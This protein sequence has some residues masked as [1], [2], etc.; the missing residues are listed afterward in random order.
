MSPMPPTALTTLS[1][2]SEPSNPLVQA[3]RALSGCPPDS[4]PRL[5]GSQPLPGLPPSLRKGSAA[6]AQVGLIKRQATKKISVG[7]PRGDLR[8]RE[9]SVMMMLKK[10]SF[11]QSGPRGNFYSD[12]RS[13]IYRI[14]ARK[15]LIMKQIL[16]LV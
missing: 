9:D 4:W 3:R 10:Q 15:S 1:P 13:I 8:G 14:I 16:N 11:V 2:P 7:S 12:Y 6:V 5:Q